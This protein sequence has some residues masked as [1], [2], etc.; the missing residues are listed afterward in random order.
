M[1]SKEWL[2]LNAVECWLH[3]YGTPNTP[4]VEQYKELQKEY[5]ALWITPRTESKPKPT[6]KPRSKTTDDP[7]A[8][9]KT[10]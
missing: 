1:K 3:Y 2:I 5:L 8:T 10:V 6:R 4:T 7:S 9:T